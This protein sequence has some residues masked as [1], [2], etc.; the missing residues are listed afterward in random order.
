M[1]ESKVAYSNELLEAAFLCALYNLTF[2]ALYIKLYGSLA[3]IPMMILMTK[4]DL[5]DANVYEDICNV[6]R[7]TH[8]LDTM[9]ELAAKTGVPKSFITLIKNYEIETEL[10]TSVDILTMTALR[11]MLRLADDFFEEQMDLLNINPSA[12]SSE[13]N[14]GVEEEEEAG[15][16]PPTPSLGLDPAIAGIITKKQGRNAQKTSP[17]KPKN[18]L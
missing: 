12:Q 11:Q 17:S 15:R 4:I 6:Y 16:V 7:S 3:G 5:I 1:N 13:E 10:E 18:I 8:I 14:P 9:E 2:V